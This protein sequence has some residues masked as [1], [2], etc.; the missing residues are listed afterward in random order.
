VSSICLICG[1]L[2]TRR[3]IW[4][5]RFAYVVSFGGPV[6]MLLFGIIYLTE[7]MVAYDVT[8]DAIMLYLI[9]CGILSVALYISIRKVEVKA[10]FRIYKR[11]STVTGYPHSGGKGRKR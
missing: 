10:M 9:S 2:F 7:G 8:I 3:Y 1:L 6:V 4:V 11:V 5:W